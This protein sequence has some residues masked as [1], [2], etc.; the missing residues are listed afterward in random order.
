MFLDFVMSEIT[1]ITNIAY[2]K[3]KHKK[4]PTAINLQKKQPS[5]TNKI[6]S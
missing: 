2:F 3:F 4:S 6:N 5:G 1:N